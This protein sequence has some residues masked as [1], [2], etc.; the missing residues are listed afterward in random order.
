[1]HTGAT[2]TFRLTGT[3]GTV[4]L[5]CKHAPEE[6]RRPSQVVPIAVRKKLDSDE[7]AGFVNVLTSKYTIAGQTQDTNHRLLTAEQDVLLST[8]NQ[9]KEVLTYKWS[10]D[11]LACIIKTYEAQPRNKLYRH[12]DVV[13]ETLELLF[14]EAD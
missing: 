3:G 10:G 1:M 12:S 8:W 5:E 2:P 13:V 6:F 11:D 14:V 7:D 4:I 9:T